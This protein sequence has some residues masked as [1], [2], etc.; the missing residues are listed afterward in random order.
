MGNEESQSQQAE[1]SPEIAVAQTEEQEISNE[2]YQKEL[3]KLKVSNFYFQNRAVDLITDFNVNFRFDPSMFSLLKELSINEY[4]DVNALET[5]MDQRFKRYSERNEL[6]KEMH[7]NIRDS[8]IKLY[9]KAKPDI[10]ADFMKKYETLQQLRLDNRDLAMRIE[11]L[12]NAIL[13]HS[14]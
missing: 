4:L 11:R 6:P 10:S 2:N 12:Q 8:T 7:A 9:A 13:A 3:Q 14:Q 1:A 5:E